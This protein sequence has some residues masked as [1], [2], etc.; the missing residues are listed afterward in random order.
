MINILKRTPIERK[1]I[2]K[3]YHEVAR[4]VPSTEPWNAFEIKLDDSSVY[5]LVD[6]ELFNINDSIKA[7][8]LMIDDVLVAATCDWN[9]VIYANSST[10][11]IKIAEPA[12]FGYHDMVYRVKYLSTP[13][14]G[15]WD[16]LGN[17][18]VINKKWNMG[19]RGE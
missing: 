13:A 12:A 3:E 16:G 11:S 9:T 8:G 14:N 19:R 18:I 2:V 10:N 4:Y 1:D 5:T 17:P 6:M 7:T 15:Y